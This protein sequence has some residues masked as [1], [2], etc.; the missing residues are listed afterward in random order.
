MRLPNVRAVSDALTVLRVVGEVA[1]GG[2]VV[3][4]RVREGF[5][6]AFNVDGPLRV[7]QEDLPE[8]VVSS[9]AGIR[10]TY[11]LTVEGS[12]R[13]AIELARRFA[14]ELV[15]RSDGVVYDTQADAV[16]WPRGGMRKFKPEPSRQID[17]VHF[18]WFVRREDL[19]SD[20]PARVFDVLR[21][22]MP[23]TLPRRFGSFEP[24]Q[25]RLEEAGRDGFIAAWHAEPMT[26]FWKGTS[27]SL[28][29]SM[30]GLGDE[31]IGAQYAGEHPVGSV[32]LSFDHRA[33]LDPRWREDAVELFV[34][35]AER[36]PCL[37]R[38]RRRRSQR[39]LQP[40]EP[41]VWARYRD[42]PWADRAERLDG[43]SELPGLVGVVRESV[44]ATRREPCT[45]RPR[46]SPRL[47]I[48]R[49]CVGDAGHPSSCKGRPETVAVP[50]PR[51]EGTAATE[52]P[53]EARSQG[54]RDTPG[55]PGSESGL[56]SFPKAFRGREPDTTGQ[57][58][59]RSTE[60]KSVSR[61]P[62]RFE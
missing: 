14:R 20:L 52:P 39:W 25:G 46:R 10:W 61:R 38:Q 9:A 37:L 11:Q 53:C 2:F 21:N 55:V 45:R 56:I 58:A 6:Y 42:Q 13:P 44:S 43:P 47:R 22:Y 30:H 7:E 57:A 48:A 40:A 51:V 1:S 19:P 32:R 15:A 36:P 16:V 49:P 23:E 29:G 12:S 35:L 59:H 54:D 62:A 18:E 8:A 34:G 31:L 5:D 27:P 28:D 3:E 33:F 17:L 41:L 60:V 24:L 4:R 26:L 50:T